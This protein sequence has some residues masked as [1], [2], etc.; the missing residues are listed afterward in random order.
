MAYNEKLANKIREALSEIP[1]VEEKKMFG[2]LAFLVNDKMCINVSGEKLMCRYDPKLEDK[3]SAKN[4]F[5]KVLMKG[6]DFKGYCYVKPEGFKT[7][8]DFDFWIKLCLE[9]NKEAKSSKTKS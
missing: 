4:G 1:N 7:K 8:K 3:I 2:G 6:K 5:E 9:F